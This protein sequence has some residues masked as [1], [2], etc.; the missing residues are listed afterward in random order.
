MDGNISFAPQPAL[1]PALG[2]AALFGSLLLAGLFGGELARRLKL[3][4]L[5]GWLLAGLLLGHFRRVGPWTF[6][7][8]YAAS[9]SMRQLGLIVFFAGAGT[10]AG[11]A[12][13]GLRAGTVLAFLGLGTAVALLVSAVVLLWGHRRMGLSLN[14]LGGVLAATQTQSSLLD[15]AQAQTRN[16]LPA[17]SY[18]VVY[19][20]AT[21]LKLVLAQLL[22]IRLV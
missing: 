11:A 21:V 5:L 18:A 9:V 22:L 12:L 10:V 20:L 6:G 3:P 13:P 19:P 4:R 14:E 2:P 8:P 7:V 15:F 16:D 1:P 17:Q